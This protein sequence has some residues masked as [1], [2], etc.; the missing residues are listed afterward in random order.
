[1]KKKLI[2][3]F[4]LIMSSTCMVKADEFIIPCNKTLFMEQAIGELK[5]SDEIVIRFQYRNDNRW[6]NFHN[7]Q[8]N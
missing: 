6:R 5:L 8:K 2:A 4:L 7:E 3:L 1:M